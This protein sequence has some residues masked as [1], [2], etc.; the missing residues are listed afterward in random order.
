[1]EIKIAIQGIEMA[2]F[3][4]KPRPKDIQIEQFSIDLKIT[5]LPDPLKKM[6][7]AVTNI[8]VK[9][10]N[11]INKLASISVFFIYRIENFEE[12]FP[13]ENDI[14]L[15]PD[16][17]RH[18]INSISI[19]TIRGMLFSMLQGTY[20]Q[21]AIIPIINVSLLTAEIK[22]PDLQIKE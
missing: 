1:M 6:A 22:E 20:L 12:V 16:E 18:M 19:S 14:Y 15:I 4:I 2:A 8:G 17:A 13:F 21:R 11:N 5:I 3:E 7:I 10:A 9:D